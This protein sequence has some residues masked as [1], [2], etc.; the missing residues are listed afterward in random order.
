MH[1][2]IMQYCIMKNARST[3]INIKMS[4]RMLMWHTAHIDL[5]KHSTA[6]TYRSIFQTGSSFYT[7]FRYTC[8]TILLFMCTKSLFSITYLTKWTELKNFQ[9]S[10]PSQVLGTARKP[11]CG[12]LMWFLQIQTRRLKHSSILIKRNETP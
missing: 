1:Y 10:T 9:P 2:E 3:L 8:T 4:K 7:A 12:P 11:L 5:L 6:T